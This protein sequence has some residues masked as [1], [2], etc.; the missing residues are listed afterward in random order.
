VDIRSALPKTIPQA[1]FMGSQR[2]PN[3]NLMTPQQR[4]LY[5]QRLQQQQWQMQ[6]QRAAQ[7]GGSSAISAMMAPSAVRGQQPRQNYRR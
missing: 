1:H 3:L 5:Q 6:Q 7:L 4:Q 2:G